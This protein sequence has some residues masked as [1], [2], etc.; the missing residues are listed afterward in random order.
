VRLNQYVA[1]AS[2][3]SRRAADTAIAA[4]RVTVGGQ[5]AGLGQRVPDG[6]TVELDGKALKL[7]ASFTYILLHKPVG[8][9]TSRARQG[10]DPTVYELLPEQYRQLR[11]VGRLDRDSSGLLILTDDGSFILR[12]THPS[13]AKTKEYLLELGRPLT[14]ADAAKLEAGVQLED[15]PSRVHVLDNQGRHVRA[16]LGEGRNRQL[17]RTFGALGYTVAALHRGQMGTFGL[18]SLKA[19]KWRVISSEELA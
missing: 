15:G 3:L 10:S 5:P 2:G 12:H 11:P 4:G 19:G 13:F 1:S 8:Y 18:G 9:V 16:A 17:R 14:S 7:P 6:A